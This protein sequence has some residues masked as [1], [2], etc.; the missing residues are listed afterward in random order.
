[1]NAKNTNRKARGVAADLRRRAQISLEQL[2]ISNWPFDKVK[3]DDFTAKDV[4]EV[5]MKWS[6]GY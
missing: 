3:A 4:K 6:N 1:M 2:A 5:Q